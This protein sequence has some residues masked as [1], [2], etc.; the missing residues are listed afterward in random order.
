[1][2]KTFT[3]HNIPEQH[4][5]L[6]NPHINKKKKPIFLYEILN[7]RNVNLFTIVFTYSHGSQVN[8][9][10]KAWKNSIFPENKWQKKGNALDG[11]VGIGWLRV[12]RE[13]EREN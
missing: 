7:V 3:N 8:F 9:Q 1:M 2:W 10:T 4:K 11:F 5:T 13:K 12:N 6:V